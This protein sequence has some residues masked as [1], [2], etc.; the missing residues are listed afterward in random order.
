MPEQ[1]QERRPKLYPLEAFCLDGGTQIR[2]E[3]CEPYIAELTAAIEAKKRLPPIVAF[4]DAEAERLYV[5]DG[6]HRYYGHQ[7]AKLEKIAAVVYRGTVQDAVRYAIKSNHTHGL[8]RTNPDKRNAVLFALRDPEWGLKTTRDLGELCGVSHNLVAS[9]R[10]EQEPAE[11]QQGEPAAGQETTT[12]ETAVTKTTTGGG[13][14]G[15]PKT[16]ADKLA[17]D[18]LGNPLPRR[19]WPVFQARSAMEGYA[20]KLGT[21]K[22]GTIAALKDQ[23]E[24]RALDLIGL[25]NHIAT[26]EE[27][28]REAK[29]HC[30]CPLCKGNGCE[31]CKKSGWLTRVGYE[32]IPREKRWQKPDAA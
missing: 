10:R 21:L 30:L 22:K 31:A 26:A 24:A 29:P 32:G 11:E 9:I 18:R 23:P 5:A 25:D 7:R 15:K 28:L 2:T 17:T 16:A 8:R 12:S 14:P 1:E 6:F 20:R 13:K 4:W 19:L 3:L 27:L